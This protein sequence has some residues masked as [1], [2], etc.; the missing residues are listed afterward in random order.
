MCA[1]IESVSQQ[2][3]ATMPEAKAPEWRRFG[4]PAK[5]EVEIRWLPDPETFERRPAQ[6]GWSMGQ[7]TI[8]V[9]RRERTDPPSNR[10]KPLI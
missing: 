10:R 7:L 6:Y 5:M 2:V 3:E 9:G 8:R 1:A 4:D